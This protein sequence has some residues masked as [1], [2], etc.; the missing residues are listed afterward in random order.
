MSIVTLKIPKDDRFRKWC[1][2]VDATTIDVTRENGYALTAPFARWGDN[3]SLK[4]GQY[5]ICAAETGSM[6]HHSY[7]FQI[8][9]G[10][11]EGDAVILSEDEIRAY[12]ATS[13]LSENVKAKALNSVPYAL[14]AYVTAKREETI[15]TGVD[16]LTPLRLER[17]QLAARLAEIDAQ[18][19]GV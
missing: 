8:W 16:T 17:A 15:L 13:S 12:V 3:V 1:K 5:A 18:L 6:K 10:G 2:V 9:T 4:T 11:D 19:S 14:A 7:D